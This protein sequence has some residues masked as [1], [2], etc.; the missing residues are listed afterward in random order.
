MNETM[1]KVLI[2]DDVHPLLL[3]GLKNL[4]FDIHYDPSISRDWVLQ[5]IQEYTGIIINSRMYM[6]E[7]MIENGS[8]LN[9]IGRLGSGLEIIDQECA[10][11]NQVKVYNSPEGNCNAVAEHA[12]G[13]I[14]ALAN[15]LLKA[16]RQV[17]NLT[18]DRE[19]N[20]GWE[21][22]GKTI[23][24][25]GY[26]HTGSS[27]A[28]VL[29]GLGVHV[30]AY[31]LYK[32][33]YAEKDDHVQEVTLDY[34]QQGS[35]IISL[36]VPLND[37]THHLV[38]KSFLQ[39]CKDD[40]VLINTSRGPVVNTYDLIDALD[41]G[42]LKGAC[43]DVFE[44]EKISTWTPTEKRLYTRLYENDNV[45]LSPHVAGWTK[46]SKEKL[47]KVLMDKISCSF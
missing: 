27:F 16:D 24:I 9:F 11:K 39:K 47:A 21:L 44:N 13:M 30:L 41:Q 35:D 25:I 14:L 5:H 10:K 15:Q 12:L 43:L 17:R 2:T 7:E 22:K 45:I 23:G 33:D 4:D 26:G 32:T 28:R 37:S 29:S 8:Q 46:E 38:S 34:L 42:K 40:L 31:D 1:A 20:R 18:W 3:E 36:H 6:D 19:A